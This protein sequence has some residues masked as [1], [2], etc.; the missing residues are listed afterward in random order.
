[1]YLDPKMSS[2]LIPPPTKPLVREYPCPHANN[3]MEAFKRYSYTINHCQ[4]HSHTTMN[5][6]SLSLSYYLEKNPA[7]YFKLFTPSYPPPRMMSSSTKRPYRSTPPKLHPSSPLVKVPLPFSSSQTLASV[8]LKHDHQKK[9]ETMPGPLFSECPQR[10]SWFVV[11]PDFRREP[12]MRG[13]GL[14]SM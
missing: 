13:A 14:G 6:A 12:G 1:M 9:L 2:L 4:S 3:L 5:T 8:L 11:H 7:I 10:G